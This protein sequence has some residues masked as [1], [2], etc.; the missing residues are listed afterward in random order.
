MMNR[1]KSALKWILP[2]RVISAI[3]SKRAAWQKKHF[4]RRLVRHVYGGVPL[5]VLIADPE[6]ATW[7]DQDWTDVL[8]LEQVKQSRLKPG[9][10]VFDIGAHQ[11][12]FACIFCKSIEPTGRLIAIDPH[13]FNLEVARENAL[14]NKS[15]GIEFVQSAVWF[16]PGTVMFSTKLNGR[17]GSENAIAVP[18]TTIDL[19]AEKYG[20]PDVVIIDVEGAEEKVLQGASKV[21]AAHRTDW[22]V[23]MHVTIGLEDFGGSVD[24]VTQMFNGYQLRGVR[25][26]EPEPVELNSEIVRGRFQLLAKC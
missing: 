17:V 11:G 6:G 20:M 19:L 16:Q 1:L 15:R 12:V 7:Y 13:A 3:R 8:G 4:R 18:A 14:L 23:E 10:L 5:E 22:I 2:N 25:D 26:Y 21:L 24:K 9:A